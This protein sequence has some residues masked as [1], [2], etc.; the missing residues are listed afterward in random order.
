MWN[1][2]LVTLHVLSDGFIAAAYLAISLTLLYLVRRAKRDV[3]FHWMLLAFG[4]FIIACGGTHVME[5]ITVW[6]P[7]Y[8][9]SGA[10]KALTAVASVT[11]AVALPG[12]VPKILVLIKDAKVAEERRVSL[13]KANLVL[14]AQSLELIAARDQAESGARAKS[15][16]L[17]TMSHEIRTPMN[18]VIGMTSILL[19]TDLSPEQAE[20]VSTIRNSG[21]ALLAIINDI[22]DFSKIEAGKLELESAEFPL[23]T[24]IEE[25]ADI[26]SAEAHRKGL[27]LIL[28]V[29]SAPNSNV[30]G[31]QNRLRQILL[32]LLSNAIK[33]TSQG[34]VAITVGFEAAEAGHVLVR[35]EVK[36]TGIGI[37]REIQSRLFRAFSQADSSTTR[38]FGGTGLGLAISRRLV[39]LMGGEIGVSSEVGKGSVFWFTALFGVPEIASHSDAQLSGRLILIVDDNATNRRVLQLQLERHGCE[40]RSAESAFS[41]LAMLAASSQDGRIFDAV[42][43]DY[44]MP[45]TDGL[46]L[47]NSIRTLPEFCEIPIVMLS[48]MADRDKATAALVDA[49]LIKP[50]RES[51]LIPLLV[52]I[53][54]Q[55]AG[56]VP[57][58]RRSLPGKPSPQLKRGSVLLAEDN[59]VNQKVA[60]LL[61]KRLGFQVHVVPNGRLALEALELGAYDAVL[62]DCQ[63]PEM[64]GFEATR[65]IRAKANLS[66]IPIIALT[67]YALQDDKLRC[68]AAGMND[69]LAKPIN[70]ETLAAKLDEW[71]NASPQSAGLRVAE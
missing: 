2:S 37:P 39:E 50:V 49:Y 8:W 58:A 45:D 29:S 14:N 60:S 5:I 48:S 71:I 4:A 56:V 26:V 42:L 41:A 18:G 7:V 70:L 68:L 30:I 65:A 46:M 54:S 44:R 32:N 38:R 40:V 13:E 34:E 61:L 10:L 35:F 57:I 9:L 43:T 11:T 64:D 47:A 19:E 24:A 33:F 66:Q 51:R 28:P 69:Y 22:L 63:M 21:E 59:V 62:M 67:A 12:L 20:Y 1:P 53:F 31:D 36:D 15:D 16:F 55:R 17:A 6:T 52:E 23:F 27:E 25:C 3:P